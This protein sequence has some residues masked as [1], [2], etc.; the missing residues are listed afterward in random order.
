[1]LGTV[2][3][4]YYLWSST[5]N[6]S[7]ISTSSEAQNYAVVDI[8][9]VKSQASKLLDGYVNNASIPIPEPTAKLGKTVPFNDPE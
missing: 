9:N 1:M 4:L 7:D 6:A 8:S 3:V 5:Q 2:G